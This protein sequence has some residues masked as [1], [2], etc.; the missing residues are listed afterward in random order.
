MSPVIWVIPG[1]CRTLASVTASQPPHDQPRTL[2]PSLVSLATENEGCGSSGIALEVGNSTVAG[3][4]TAR[5]GSG[6]AVGFSTCCC[7]AHA[8]ARNSKDVSIK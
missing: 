3:G 8:L 4:T 5:V 6:I 7:G 1:N 2:K